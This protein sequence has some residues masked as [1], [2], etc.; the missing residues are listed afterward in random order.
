MALSSLPFP[1]TALSEDCNHPLH[2]S[3]NGSVDDDW[4]LPLLTVSTSVRK[5]QNA[6]SLYT[7]T[8]TL[9]VYISLHKIMSCRHLMPPF[10]PEYNLHDFICVGMCKWVPHTWCWVLLRVLKVHIRTDVYI[11]MYNCN[12]K[13]FCTITV[14]CFIFVV[15]KY[16]CRQKFHRNILHWNYSC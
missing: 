8:C 1:S 3:Q 2:W 13:V 16:F 11:Y 9:T 14:I 15:K 4:T 6:H 10:F 7:Y 12:R 5:V